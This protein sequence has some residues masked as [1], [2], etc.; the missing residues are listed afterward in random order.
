M[1]SPAEQR[2]MAEA[3]AAE[4]A[5]EVKTSQPLVGERESPSVLLSEYAGNLPFLSRIEVL[6]GAFRGLRRSRGDGNCFYRSML[7][8]LGERL[9]SAGVVVPNAGSSQPSPPTSPMQAQYERLL[10]AASPAV[11]P[12]L[13]AVGCPEMTSDGFREA[14]ESWLLGLSAPGA[15]VESAALAPLREEGANFWIIYYARLLTALQL[16]EHAD[17]F[18]PYIFA[19][20]E[21]YSD[22]KAFCD[23][24]V[25]TADAYADQVHILALCAA[26]C[27]KVR[28]FYLDSHSG[29]L[30]TVPDDG[31]DAPVLADLL[32]RPG[33]FDILYVDG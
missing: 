21:R 7:A 3:Q 18:A 26:L 1:S 19:S 8:A 20:Y 29:M 25:L 5:S 33:H 4:I 24:E 27:G 22:V 2:H 28:I 9:V 14:F 32:Y 23:S 16:L 31:S 6:C 12:R 11:L 10:A 15:T 30:I 13:A 17:D